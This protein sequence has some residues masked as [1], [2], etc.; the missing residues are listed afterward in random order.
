MAYQA[1]QHHP[2]W[3]PPAPRKN[4]RAAKV[5][6]GL[7]GGC[8]ALVVV[9]AVASG[10][11]QPQTSTAAPLATPSGHAT[12]AAK[13]KPHKDVVTFEVAGRAPAGVDITYGN[14]TDNRQGPK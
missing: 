12:H 14:D 10:G 6:L 1:P 11:G 4:R 7:V 8:V 5:I 9:V 13:P 2:Q 3:Y